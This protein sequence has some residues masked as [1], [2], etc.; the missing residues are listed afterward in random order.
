MTAFPA[1]NKQYPL[2]GSHQGMQAEQ[3]WTILIESTMKQAGVDPSR[4]SFLAA[5]TTADGPM[6]YVLALNGRI[7]MSLKLC[8]LLALD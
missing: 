3:W 4:P 2:Y 7:Q 5:P 1:I 6:T 8:L